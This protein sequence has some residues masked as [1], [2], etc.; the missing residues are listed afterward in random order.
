[1]PRLL[2]LQPQSEMLS[3]LK[4]LEL[5]LVEEGILTSPPTVT[6]TGGG[7]SGAEATAV[8]SN[9]AVNTITLGNLWR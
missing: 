3:L 6:I 9:G 1:M 5:H 4:N 8:V 2:Q 7:G